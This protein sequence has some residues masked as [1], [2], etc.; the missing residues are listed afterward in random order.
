MLSCCQFSNVHKC[1]VLCIFAWSACDSTAHPIPKVD[2]FQMRKWTLLWRIVRYLYV[3]GIPM[4]EISSPVFAKIWQGIVNAFTL[5]TLDGLGEAHR[6]LWFSLSLQCPCRLGICSRIRETGGIVKVNFPG[7]QAAICDRITTLEPKV[8][9][10]SCCAIA[11][12]FLFSRRSMVLSHASFASVGLGP[13]VYVIK[14]L[15][16]HDWL[17]CFP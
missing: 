7:S 2:V 15:S 8:A 13:L 1:C 4:V 6:N 9:P 10:Y 17:R 16:E 14:V 11:W 12:F 5:I 3:Y